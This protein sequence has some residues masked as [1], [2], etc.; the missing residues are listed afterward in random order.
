IEAI[1]S[2]LKT[3]NYKDL[4][5]EMIE[6]FPAESMSLVSK[7]AN[8]EMYAK[9]SLSLRW[10]SK[11]NQASREDFQHF[12]D[13][14]PVRELTIDWYKDRKSRLRSGVP[15]FE[16][17]GASLIEIV[18]R[19]NDVTLLCSMKKIQ[20]HDLRRLFQL[21]CDSNG[22]RIRMELSV[23][24]YYEIFESLEDDSEIVTENNGAHPKGRHVSG[25]I[26]TH[27]R[28]YQPTT[29]RRVSVTFLKDPP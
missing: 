9:E 17:D 26:I 29:R 10:Y 5:L 28:A 1:L 11:N 18:E 25:A 15:N 3:A 8:N 12:C 21:V 19:Q 2:I 13:L 20:L 24:Q 7:L 16:I 14:P 27:D 23:K 22:K 6:K 4:D